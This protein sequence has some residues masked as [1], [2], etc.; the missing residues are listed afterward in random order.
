[1]SMLDVNILELMTTELVSLGTQVIILHSS[2][3]LLLIAFGTA[4]L[5]AAGMMIMMIFLF[6]MIFQRQ[7]MAAVV[8]FRFRVKYLVRKIE[9][10]KSTISGEIS[11][12]FKQ[13][14][15]QQFF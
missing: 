10:K 9:E 2:V 5:I 12:S 1:M 13:S 3:L 14:L 15:M 4:I 7:P 8:M 11:F 6:G